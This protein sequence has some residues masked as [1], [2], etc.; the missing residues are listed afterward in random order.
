MKKKI[1][2]RE[3]DHT[4]Q[5][6][7]II[8]LLDIA[9]LAVNHDPCGRHILLCVGEVALVVKTNKQTAVSELAGIHFDKGAVQEECVL[10]LTRP[11]GAI[12]RKKEISSIRKASGKL[13]LALTKSCISR[14]R[15]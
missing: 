2:R 14:S 5:L 7:R 9:C 4:S 15:K 6:G 13:G 1:R 8:L 12:D 11:C 10:L 3:E